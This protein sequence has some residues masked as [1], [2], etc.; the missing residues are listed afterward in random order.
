MI[1]TIIPTPKT[2]QVSEKRN[3]IAPYV[4]CEYAP[5]LIYA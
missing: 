5:W 4:M 2:I 3:A 1:N